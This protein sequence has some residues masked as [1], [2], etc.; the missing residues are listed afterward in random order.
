[1]GS[2]VKNRK[3]ATLTEEWQKMQVTFKTAG[4]APNTCIL[5]NETS[6]ELM[7]AFNDEQIAYQLVPLHK[8]RNNLAEQAI[9]TCKYRFQ[10]NN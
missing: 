2:A 8:Y 9:Q 1:M 10:A 5:D 7:E 3:G 4:V 6:A